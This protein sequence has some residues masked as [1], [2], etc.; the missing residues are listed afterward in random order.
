MAEPLQWGVYWAP[1]AM[2]SRGGE[3]LAHPVVVVQRQELIAKLATVLVVPLTSNWGG[4]KTC[5]RCVTV[6]RNPFLAHDSW[7]LVQLVGAEEKR[8]LERLDLVGSLHEID[9]AQLSAALLYVL[10]VAP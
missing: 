9:V 2:R 7:A 10:G 3:H 8:S 4:V 1:V 6:A 5:V